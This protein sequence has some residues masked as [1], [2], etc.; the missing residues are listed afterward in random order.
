MVGRYMSS[1]Q[2]D[3]VTQARQSLALLDEWNA[4]MRLAEIR[5]P[6]GSVIFDSNAAA[7]T[8]TLTGQSLTGGGAQVFVPDEYLSST[9][10]RDVGPFPP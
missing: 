7:Q 3:T 5:I 10:F 1:L 6:R 2:F 8:S 9:F 4:A